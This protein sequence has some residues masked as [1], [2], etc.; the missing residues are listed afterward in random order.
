MS[1]ANVDYLFQLNTSPPDRGAGSARTSDEAITSQFGDHLSQASASFAASVFDAVR[2]PDRSST[3]FRYTTRENGYSSP[4]PDVSSPS[5]PR[6]RADTSGGNVSSP[7]PPVDPKNDEHPDDAHVHN[8]D[9][10]DHDHNDKSDDSAPASAAGAAASTSVKDAS[11]KKNAKAGDAQNGSTT[12]AQV[13]DKPS[14]PNP[15]KAVAAGAEQ[16]GQIPPDSVAQPEAVAAT[17]ATDANE[18]KASTPVPSTT[19]A[20]SSK[21]DAAT[22]TPLDVTVQNKPDEVAHGAAAK[23]SAKGAK[24]AV[25]NLASASNDSTQQI[26]TSGTESPVASAQAASAATV[27]AAA[28]K[29][30]F[31]TADTTNSNDESQ[32]DSKAA[33]ASTVTRM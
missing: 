20:E 25:A 11:T 14:S 27:T 8:S 10:A 16:G 26:A 2:P 30:N 1:Q 5:P 6:K 33:S 13:K 4:G 31:P 15:A 17:L 3:T 9:R 32:R 21:T 24:Q 12:T 28:D 7:N 23:G 29:K 18:V 22:T 19:T